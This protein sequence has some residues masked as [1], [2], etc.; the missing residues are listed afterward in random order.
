MTLR[1]GARLRSQVDTTEVIVVRP[2]SGDVEVACGGHP[3]IDVQA[4]PT[5]G[6]TPVGDQGDGTKLGK[7]YTA[8]DDSGLELL[9]TKPGT[10]RLTVDGR[11]V[12]LKEAKPLPASD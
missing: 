8:G 4:Q 9:V 1:P 10:W 6:I 12:A 5:P 11:P 7:R 2:G 3:M